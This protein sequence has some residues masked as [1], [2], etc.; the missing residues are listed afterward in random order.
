MKRI[1]KVITTVG[2]VYSSSLLGFAQLPPDK[3]AGTA[4]P[5]ARQVEAK[6]TFE[7]VCASCHGL[8]G[9]GGERGPDITS[10]A[11]AVSKA[12]GDLLKILREGQISKG[13]PSFAAVGEK[14]LRELVT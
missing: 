4:S 14:R 10:R 11:E 7:R 12:D 13:M 8:D 3:T 9:R 1:N 2:L 6:S 5:G